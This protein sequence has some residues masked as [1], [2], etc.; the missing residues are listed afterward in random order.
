MEIEKTVHEESLFG[1]S[2]VRIPLEEIGKTEFVTKDG[3]IIEILPH[4]PPLSPIRIGH[5]DY[6]PFLLFDSV[7]MD[8]TSYE[9]VMNWQECGLPFPPIEK[10]ATEILEY[11]E[12]TGRLSLIDYNGLL[13]PYEK[14]IIGQLKIDLHDKNI[15]YALKESLALWHQFVRQYRGG[16]LQENHV[17]LLES[18]ADDFLTNFNIYIEEK[19]L[20]VRTIPM[21]LSSY[22]LDINSTLILSNILDTGFYDWNDYYPFYK[23]KLGR[24]GQ[25]GQEEKEQIEML[26]KTFEIFL[27]D[28]RFETPEQ[29][30]RVIEDPRIEN[31]RAF[32]SELISKKAEMDLRYKVSIL[33]EVIKIDEKIDSYSKFISRLTAPIGFIP[34]VGTPIQILL[35]E[36]LTKRRSTRE[37]EPLS[38]FFLLR[39]VSKS[40][41]KQDILG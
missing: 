33:E 1:R 37:R 32:V 21:L 8:E 11:L 18:L 16:L 35:Q 22:L 26:E 9:T 3:T 23:Y 4:I 41:S 25:I 15:Y 2:K 38:W 7:L 29:I 24:A 14:N 13:E 28:F 17:S 40:Y 20:G 10:N 31:L 34:W 39:D 12:S 19:Y 5:F 30:E 27:P 36:V 6:F